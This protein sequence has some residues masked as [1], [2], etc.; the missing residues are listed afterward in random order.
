MR[1]F[2]PGQAATWTKTITEADVEAFA[3][4]T[5]DFNPLHVDGKYA[6]RSRFGERIAHGILT[7]GLISAVLGMRLPGP[8]GIFLSQT[9][10]FVRPVRFGDTITARAEVVSW[11]PEKRL[12]ILHT[13]CA[14][15]RGEAVLDGEAALLVEPV[16]DGP[17]KQ[18]EVEQG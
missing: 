17:E 4:I 7:A 1:A 13:T 11:R 3:G 8:G 15:Q 14:N 2:E 5:G 6:A 18:E 9:L 16:P 10:M 12:L